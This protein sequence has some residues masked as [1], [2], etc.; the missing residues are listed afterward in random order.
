MFASLTITLHGNSHVDVDLQLAAKQIVTPA[1]KQS[2]VSF[3]CLWISGGV[4]RHM[5]RS[6]DFRKMNR[7]VFGF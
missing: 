3:Y 2:P 6:A 7:I 5:L 4:L 1:V